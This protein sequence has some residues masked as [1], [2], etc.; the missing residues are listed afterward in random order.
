MNDKDSAITADALVRCAAALEKIV[1]LLE[2]PPT[3]IDAPHFATPT[4]LT[5]LTGGENRWTAT[6]IPLGKYDRIVDADGHVY[7]GATGD[8]IAEIDRGTVP[9]LEPN[10][11]WW[12]AGRDNL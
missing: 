12:I 7:D 9:H 5:T 4:S 10:P 2:H 11:K 6:H 1:T 3:T 8:L